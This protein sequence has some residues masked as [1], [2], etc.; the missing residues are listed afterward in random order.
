MV[1]EELEIPRNAADRSVTDLLPPELVQSGED[2][3]TAIRVF[4]SVKST[5]DVTLT[6]PKVLD[7]L[8]P[9][10]QGD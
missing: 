2:A 6:I 10:A 8:P 7:V 3:S 5:A 4:S 1:T 9:F